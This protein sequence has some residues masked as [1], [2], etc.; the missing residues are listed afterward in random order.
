M[1]KVQKSKWS[2]QCKHAHHLRKCK[3]LETNK[4]TAEWKAQ[5]ITK[6]AEMYNELNW[7][8]WNVIF[9]CTAGVRACVRVFKR[10]ASRCV[11]KS[12]PIEREKQPYLATLLNILTLQR[13]RKLMRP[14]ENEAGMKLKLWF[15]RKFKWYRN[16][17]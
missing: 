3:C 5:S 10:I 2:K 16:S 15:W 8:I 13:Q 11:I 9:P 1:N 4:V 7:R 14:T 17:V 12:S 6:N